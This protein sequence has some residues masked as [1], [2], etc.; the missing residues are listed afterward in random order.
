MFTVHCSLFTMAKTDG[1]GTAFRIKKGAPCKARR[2]EG[3]DILLELRGKPPLLLKWRNASTPGAAQRGLRAVRLYS[4]RLGTRIPQRP[5]RRQ[6]PATHFFQK[7]SAAGFGEPRGNNMIRFTAPK[8]R[9]IPAQG[10][11]LGYA[12]NHPRALK[13]RL[14]GGVERALVLS[15]PFR[16]LDPLQHR[17]RASPWAGISRPLGALIGHIVSTRSLGEKT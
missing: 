13:G 15:R 1:M 9:I 6:P 10:K 8:G 7:K 16:A 3:G 2:P 5:W 4:A 14:N 11:A 12:M 17:P